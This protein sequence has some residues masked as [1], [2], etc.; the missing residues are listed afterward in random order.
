MRLA[1]AVIGVLP[2]IT[3][4]TWPSGVRSSARK[5]SAPFGKMVLPALFSACRKALRLAIRGLKKLCRQGGAP[6]VFELDAGVV[7]HPLPLP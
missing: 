2:R 7:H 1:I 6:A 3:T 4:F 5:Y